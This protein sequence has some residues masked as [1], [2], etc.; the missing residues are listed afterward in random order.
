MHLSHSTSVLVAHYDYRLVALSVIIAILASYAAL[1][2]A[3]RVT[4]AQGSSRFACLSGGAVAMGSGIWAMHYVGMLAYS[5][6]VSVSYDWP[7]VLA[8]FLAAAVAAAVSLFIASREEMGA[9]AISVGGSVMGAAVASMHY[10]GMD[11]MR[12]P[13]M[14][15]YSTAI[16]CV[17][18]LLAVVIS[19]VALWLSFHLRTERRSLRR[20]TD[21]RHPQ[22]P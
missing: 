12:L 5:L 16:V 10:I 4:A 18:V 6:P 13:A 7:T 20:R 11:A 21:V 8:S 1:D 3:G 17:S 15:H 2:L 19:A 14:C 9:L 22:K